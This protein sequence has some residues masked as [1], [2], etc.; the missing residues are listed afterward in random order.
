MANGAEQCEILF[1][2]CPEANLGVDEDASVREEPVG[3]V[4]VG[5]SPEKGEVLL[6]SAGDDESARPSRD[7]EHLG[8]GFAVDAVDDRCAEI[9]RAFGRLGMIGVD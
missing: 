8:N 6:G 4:C 2:G 7:F 3:R 5:L 9:D 1:A